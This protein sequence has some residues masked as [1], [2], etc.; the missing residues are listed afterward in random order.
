MLHD[1]H[2]AQNAKR[3]GTV[4]AVYLIMKK[5]ST[6]QPIDQDGDVEMEEEIIPTLVATLCPEQ[7]L[8][9]EF[10]LYGFRNSVPG[11]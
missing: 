9:R 3:P 5:Q 8:K 11:Y 2:R 7:H 10:P 4:H 1:F 6:Q